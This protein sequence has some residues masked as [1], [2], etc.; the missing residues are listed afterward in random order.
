[1]MDIKKQI[2]YWKD[3]AEEDI[4][5]AKLLFSGN[6]FKESLFF[7]HLT[8]EKILKAH[9]VKTNKDFA[10]KS[11]KLTFLAKNSSIDISEEMH[12]LFGILMTYQLEG[13]Y[14][15]YSPFIPETDIIES[16]ISKTEEVFQCL[17]KKL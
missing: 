15:D 1:M 7:C 17:I 9:F 2:E 13:R 14:P 12:T 5:T 6:K 11:H 4:D 10:P 16:Y 3:S 8:I